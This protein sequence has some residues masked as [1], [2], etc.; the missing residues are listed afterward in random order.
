MVITNL[1]TRAVCRP[2]F[3]LSSESLIGSRHERM[4]AGFSSSRLG[5]RLEFRSD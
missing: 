1:P 5:Q 2:R 3:G 4:L